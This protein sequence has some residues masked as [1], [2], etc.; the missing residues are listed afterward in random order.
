MSFDDRE[1]CSQTSPVLYSEGVQKWLVGQSEHE[2][3]QEA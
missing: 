3:L 2:H 1:V